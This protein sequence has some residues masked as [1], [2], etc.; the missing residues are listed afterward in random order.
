MTTNRE[1]TPPP[2]QGRGR[3]FAPARVCFDTTVANIHNMEREG[4]TVMRSH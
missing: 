4:Y 2:G 1:S 3:R